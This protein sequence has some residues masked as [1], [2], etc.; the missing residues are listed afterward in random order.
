MASI[1]LKHYFFA[2]PTKVV[3]NWPLARVIQSEKNYHA[4]FQW[5]VDIGQYHVDFIPR[6]AKKSHV[7]AYFI[8]EWT[9]S[10]M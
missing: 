5:V 6:R 10:G 1:K 7:L 8:A 4:D 9:D 2:H 3:S